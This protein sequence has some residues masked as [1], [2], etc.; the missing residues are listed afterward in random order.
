MNFLSFARLLISIFI[1]RLDGIYSLHTNSSAIKLLLV[2]TLHKQA[3]FPTVCRYHCNYM[4]CKT[5]DKNYLFV[6]IRTYVSNRV[7]PVSHDSTAQSVSY[8]L[9]ECD[10]ST[11]KNTG[12][13]KKYK[14]R[15]TMNHT[16]ESGMLLNILQVNSAN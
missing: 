14:Q 1:G 6:D 11:L 10:S 5:A 16:S 4:K 3:N 2:G 15:I 8:H 9:C 13:G 12:H 7:D